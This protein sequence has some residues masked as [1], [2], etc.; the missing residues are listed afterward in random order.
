[1]STLML[2]GGGTLGPVTPLLAVV[3]RLREYE[4]DMKFV[5]IGTD[6]GPERS[7]IEGRGIE[8]YS[9][10][11]AKLPRYLSSKLVTLPFDIL[12]AKK[13]AGKIIDA[14]RPK[15]VLSAGGFT[16]VP[17]IYEAT[18]RKIPCIAHQL[19]VRALLSNRI[20][21]GYCRY[22]TTSYPY[23]SSPF[24]KNVVTYH[25]PTPVRFDLEKLPSRE[26]ACR[27]FGL[28]PS[29]PIILVIGGGT[30]AN[31]LN[32][33]MALIARKLPEHL[34]VIHMTGRG[35]KIFLGMER[36]GYVMEEFL[37]EKILSAYV[38][39]D[40]VVSRAGFGSLSELACLSKPVIFVPLPNSPQ[41]DNAN[42]FSNSAIVLHQKSAA[43]SKD[44]L[45]QIVRLSEDAELRKH[46]GESL[47]KSLT[48]DRGDVLAKLV[49]SA[50]V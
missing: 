4:P 35:K 17:V 23:P 48:T 43:F 39:S 3:D 37:G 20:V 44:L 14:Y 34:Q 13:E 36:K 21:A 12:R 30:G 27:I 29:L 18:K 11:E 49:M 9:I 22:I 7:L 47:N 33:V 2:A 25:I 41:E 45:E 31:A 10:T 16:A 15:L 38:A 46:L 6:S 50:M 40:I 42:A 32:E 5:W 1:M 26:E 19:D 28:D 8:F 24:P